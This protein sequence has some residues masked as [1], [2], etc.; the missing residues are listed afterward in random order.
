[1]AA[2]VVKVTS[3]VTRRLAPAGQAPV[4]RL[5]FEPSPSPFPLASLSYGETP[6]R[7]RRVRRGFG[8]T[9][10]DRSVQ[11][12]LVFVLGALFSLMSVWVVTFLYGMAFGDDEDLMPELSD[13][14]ILVL[15]V[16]IPASF[17]LA[18][19]VVM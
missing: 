13:A 11:F 4:K 18:W 14:P 19:A 15:L 8:R 12:F 2:S 5:L 7:R 6:R 9:R 16:L 17:A 1:M 3:V 10:G